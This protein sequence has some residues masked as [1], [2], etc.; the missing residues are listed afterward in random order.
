MRQDE[1]RRKFGAWTGTLLIVASMIGTGVFTTTGLLL[2]DID[3]VAAVLACWAVGGLLALTG[4][5]SYAELATTL[6]DNGGEFLFLSR[7]FHP[8][9]GFAAGIVSLVVG[10]SAPIAAAAIAFSLYL[11]RVVPGAPTMPLAIALIVGLSALHAWRVTVGGRFQVAITAAKVILIVALIVVGLWRADGGTLA[12]AP[13]AP[14]LATVLSPAFAVGLVLVSFAYTGWNA[15]VYV[16]G[17]LENPRRNIPLSLAAGTIIVTVLYVGLNVVFV[18]AAPV[19]QLA[20]VVEVGHV[21][22]AGLFGEHGA[23][24]LSALIALGLVSTISAYVM[25][26]PRVYEAM[27]EAYP[28][29]AFL[30]GRGAQPNR[31]PVAAIVL[32]AAVSLAMLL[33]ASFEGLLTYIGFTLS[34]FAAL[35]VAGVIVLRIR[36]PG[37]ERPYRVWGYPVTPLLFIGLMIWMIWQA[38]ALEPRV[39]LAGL[40]TLVVA[41][42]LYVAFGRTA[43][44]G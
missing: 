29:L 12:P 27:G 20:G 21:A 10:F 1:D 2:A 17:E 39:A 6:P 44:N 30:S 32:Q 42:V 26:G 22:A 14:F 9:L 37:L 3:S 38:I 31:G 34:I 36:E 16:A 19:E 33:T 23:R 41:G 24:W 43:P 8:A 28:R 15:S 40:V 4:A 7:I 18:T 11:E 35:T 13:G 5:L 25:S